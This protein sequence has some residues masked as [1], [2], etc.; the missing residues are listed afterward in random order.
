MRLNWNICKEK[1]KRMGNSITM[2]GLSHYPVTTKPLFEMES[3]VTKLS[4]R[5]QCEI[6][7]G[8]VY[9]FLLGSTVA[10]FGWY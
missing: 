4:V 8:D 2:N 10:Y 7:G 5:H 3:E 6:G 9:M 1:G